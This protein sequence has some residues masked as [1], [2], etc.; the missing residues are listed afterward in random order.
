VGE[1]TG[2]GC[3]HHMPPSQCLGDTRPGDAV[4]VDLYVHLQSRGAGH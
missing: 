2:V 4:F 3:V 1:R